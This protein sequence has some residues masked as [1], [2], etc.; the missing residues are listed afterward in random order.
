MSRSLLDRNLIIHSS[1]I[2]SISKFSKW[3]GFNS[4]Q[5]VKAPKRTNEHDMVSALK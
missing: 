1:E 5:N 3:T 4:L 2:G